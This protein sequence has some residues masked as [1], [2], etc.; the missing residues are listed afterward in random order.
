MFRKQYESTYDILEIMISVGSVHGVEQLSAHEPTVVSMS[1]CI[2]VVVV[3]ISRTK[4]CNHQHCWYSTTISTGAHCSWG[5]RGSR[6]KGVVCN[7]SQHDV[8]RVDIFGS[9]FGFAVYF[10]DST[11]FVARHGNSIS[12]TIH[13]CQISY[14][15]LISL[16][17]STLLFEVSW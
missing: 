2:V 15:E 17:E 4:Q 7:R 8:S 12:I 10:V 11:F 3:V 5:G 16:R 13:V 9:W 6:T 14:S 1:N